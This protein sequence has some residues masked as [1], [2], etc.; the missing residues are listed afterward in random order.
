MRSGEPDDRRGPTVA[1][2]GVPARTGLLC[3]EQVEVVV[4]RAAAQLLVYRPRPALG[5]AQAANPG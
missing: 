2:R 5:T 1:Q 4:P 3:L